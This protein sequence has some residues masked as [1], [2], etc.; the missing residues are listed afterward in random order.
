LPIS[1]L[2]RRFVEV[3]PAES[4]RAALLFTSLVLSAGFFVFTESSSNL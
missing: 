1:A 3:W 4:A 2:S